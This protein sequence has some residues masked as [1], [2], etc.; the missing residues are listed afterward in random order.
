MNKMKK[1]HKMKKYIPHM[2]F[3]LVPVLFLLG[4]SIYQVDQ[5]QFALELQFGEVKGVRLEPGLKMKIPFIRQVVFFDNRIQHVGF[6]SGDINEVLTADQK[7][8]KLDAFAKYRI[9]DVLSFYRAVKDND[10][11]KR[12][13]NSILESTIREVAG[14]VEFLDILRSKR[15]NMMEYIAEHVNKQVDKFGVEIVDVRITTLSLPEQSR[16]AV[17][18]RMRTDRNKEAAEIRA[19]GHQESQVIRASTDRERDVTLANARK[20]ASILTGQG[21][22]EAARIFIDAAK[23]DSAF[24]SFYKSISAY[25]KSMNENNTSIILNSDNNKIFRMLKNSEE[26]VDSSD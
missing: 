21:D 3:I 10:T 12:R 6:H 22:A 24:Y 23:K 2:L 7:T 4:V 9:T 17:Y 19:M 14:T 13:L 18:N 20:E 16:R 15:G 25:K 26:V 1:L 5:R 8:L 11:F